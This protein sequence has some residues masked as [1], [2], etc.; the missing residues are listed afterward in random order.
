MF[1]NL[2]ED[3]SVN[4]QRDHRRISSSNSRSLRL[5]STKAALLPIKILRIRNLLHQPTSFDPTA[6]QIER[7]AMHGLQDSTCIYSDHCLCIHTAG[8]SNS[9]RIVCLLVI[10]APRAERNPAALHESMGASMLAQWVVAYCQR[11]SRVRERRGELVAKCG[12][13]VRWCLGWLCFRITASQA[14][15]NPTSLDESMGASVLA[16][17]I[18]A[19]CQR[20]S[21][22]QRGRDMLVAKCGI[23]VWWCLSWL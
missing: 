18:V 4:H 22:V 16:R 21:S 9:R 8:G 12:V 17:G 1:A 7:E 20:R 2:G 14:E 3:F 6:P 11:G 10:A 5:F 23:T 15:R 13:A 19:Y